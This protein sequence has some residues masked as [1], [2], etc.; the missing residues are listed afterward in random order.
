MTKFGR[1]VSFHVV[2][3]AADIRSDCSLAGRNPPR[4]TSAAPSRRRPTRAVLCGEQRGRVGAGLSTGP[5]A[6]IRMRAVLDASL[7]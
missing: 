6:D 1:A 2:G 7:I 4:Q 5:V 3:R